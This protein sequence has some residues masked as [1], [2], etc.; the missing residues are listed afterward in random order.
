MAQN[1]LSNNLGKFSHADGGQMNFYLNYYKNN[2]MRKYDNPPIGIILCASKNDTFVEY[3]IGG[4]DNEIFVSKYLIE[5]PN[6]DELKQL[7]EDDMKSN[8]V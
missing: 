4:L 3:T 1:L 5:Y 7:I 6:F 2:E 8:V